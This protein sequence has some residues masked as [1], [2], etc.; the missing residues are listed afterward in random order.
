MPASAQTLLAARLVAIAYTAKGDLL[1][2]CIDEINE[3]GCACEANVM[4]VEDDHPVSFGLVVTHPQFG[5]ILAFRG[6]DDTVEALDDLDAVLEPCPLSDGGGASWHRGFARVFTSLTMPT[7]PFDII[8]GHSL[9]CPL[10]AFAA[11][12]H[13]AGRLILFASPKPGNTVLAAD[14]L[15]NLGA[16]V[17]SYANRD[18][19]VPRLPITVDWPWKFEDFQPIIPPTELDGGS[20]VPPIPS[21]WLAAH[22][23]DNY[24]RL[25][26]ALP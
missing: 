8:A 18:D 3:L 16:G 21:D 22:R 12:S 5:R 23:L 15:E 20:V 7:G 9:G 10:A 14:V 17:E 1:G 11:L 13:G 2:D 24:I 25:L 6:T 4:G 19:A 26:S